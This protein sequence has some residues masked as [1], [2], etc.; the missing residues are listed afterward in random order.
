MGKMND[1]DDFIRYNLVQVKFDQ[2]K[3]HRLC[4]IEKVLDYA[5]LFSSGILFF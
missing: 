1:I 4:L 3:N 2:A 5:H